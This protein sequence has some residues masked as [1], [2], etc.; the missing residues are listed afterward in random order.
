MSSTS[1]KERWITV[2][3]F[4]KAK[5]ALEKADIYVGNITVYDTGFRMALES[6]TEAAGEF[7]GGESWG[8]TTQMLKRTSEA[9]RAIEKDMAEDEEYVNNL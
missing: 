1:S 6:P 7:N 9:C 8:S 3:D 4:E 2:G 5:A